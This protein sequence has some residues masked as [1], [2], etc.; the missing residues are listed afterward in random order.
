MYLALSADTIDELVKPALRD[1]WDQVKQ[2][3]FPRQD[4]P[5][6]EAFDKRTPGALK[7]LIILIILFCYVYPK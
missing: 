7:L 6:I 4:T 3:W 2:N 1:E 5:K